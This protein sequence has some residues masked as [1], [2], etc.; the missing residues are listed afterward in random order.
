MHTTP[1]SSILHITPMHALLL[2][3][4]NHTQ[5]RYVLAHDARM[6][7][8]VYI[9]NH[10]QTPQQVVITKIQPRVFYDAYA[11]LTFEGNFNLRNIST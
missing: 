4:H 5:P 7:D 9:V 10:G 6:V 3:K 1:L 11:P 2:K 8:P